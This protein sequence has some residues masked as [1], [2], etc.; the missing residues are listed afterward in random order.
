MGKYTFTRSHPNKKE[1]SEFTGERR[2]LHS[3]CSFLMYRRLLY[4]TFRVADKVDDVMY[5]IAHRNLI[6]D[7]L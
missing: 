1:C 3:V 6:L 5:F 4:N 7:F 2:S